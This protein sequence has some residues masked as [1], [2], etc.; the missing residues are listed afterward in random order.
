MLQDGGSAFPPALASLPCGDSA[1]Y[2]A[3][4][5][6]GPSCIIN[7][8]KEGYDAFEYSP[9][10]LLA[11]ARCSRQAGSL[12]RTDHLIIGEKKK[13]S[14]TVGEHPLS[15]AA[16]ARCGSGQRKGKDG[17]YRNKKGSTT[18]RNSP[19]IRRS[20]TN[21][22]KSRKVEVRVFSSADRPSW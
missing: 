13:C 17:A 19:F 5:R 10:I 14:A 6:G 20:G 18:L 7:R 4:G 15:S 11:I 21:L 3:A 2:Q 22:R 16:I 1:L 9:F 8:C 12:E